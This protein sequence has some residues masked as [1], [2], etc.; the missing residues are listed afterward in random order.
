MLKVL[1]LDTA[2]SLHQ[3]ELGLI[4]C[5]MSICAGSEV[6]R[7]LCG[8]AN[9]VYCFEIL[10]SVFKIVLKQLCKLVNDPG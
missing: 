1:V 2:V 9:G 10:N 5:L 6:F 8:C 3:T 4:K 7:I